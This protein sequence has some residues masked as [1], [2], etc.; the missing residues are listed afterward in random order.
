VPV[1]TRSQGCED[2]I[3]I[4]SESRIAFDSFL[5]DADG[6]HHRGVVASTEA[7]AD[8][9]KA[10]AT[11]FTS[12]MHGDSSR[13]RHRSSSGTS[14]K[15]IGHEPVMT[16]GRRQDSS[17]RG[18]Q[19][20][21]CRI[22]SYR[23]NCHIPHGYHK[24]RSQSRS[25]RFR[26]IAT[27]LRLMRQAADN[28]APRF[29]DAVKK[30]RQSI[31]MVFCR[32][33]CDAINQHKAS[34]D[35]A[36]MDTVK[37]ITCSRI[38]IVSQ[39]I[40]IDQQASLTIARAIVLQPLPVLLNVSQENSS[41]CCCSSQHQRAVVARIVGQQRCDPQA[42]QVEFTANQATGSASRVTTLGES[43]HG[44]VNSLSPK[45]PKRA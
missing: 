17:N 11:E 18:L 6:M 7:T 16:G 38:K 1:W 21:S 13:D 44:G 28:A 22:N 30:V 26:E 31:K 27:A 5:S 15:I 35:P 41:R 12:Q 32:E 45:C 33:L 19:I 36:A 25:D 37:F 20:S 3:T 9:G 23:P 43:P 2:G 42:E 34:G 14:H 10:L 4:L 39:S 24:P 8:C 29:T 40:G